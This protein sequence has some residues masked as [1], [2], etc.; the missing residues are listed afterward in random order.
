MHSR[1]LNTIFFSKEKSES[2]KK[3]RI[4]Q[5]NLVHVQGLPENLVKKNLLESAEYFG[6]Y[7]TI[8]KLIIS[9]KI[10]P[11]NK[12]K[13]FSVYITYKNEKEAAITILCIDSL[14]INGKIIRA[15]FGTTKYCT[16]FMNNSICPNSKNCMFLHQ[17]INNKEI[18]IDS[19][20]VFSYNEHL[21]L[22]KKII[23]F[24]NPETRIILS[25][26]KKPKSIFP[27][28]DF[29]LL[30]EEQKEKY[31]GPGNIS[32]IKS[33]NSNKNNESID[34]YL[35]N[36][37]TK[38]NLININNIYNHSINN[39]INNNI[40]NN[41]NVNNIKDRYNNLSYKDPNNSAYVNS[42]KNSY[43]LDNKNSLNNYC[44]NFNDINK[45][46]EPYELC[47]I[48]K[49]SIKHILLSKPFFEN[50]K[51]LPLKRM[52]FNYLKNDLSEKDININ[53]LLNGCLDCLIDYY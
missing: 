35:V 14:L 22:A 39:V 29:I 44:F 28:V 15:F 23:D 13:S 24:N 17:L 1:F 45:N 5:P 21:N 50:I 52:E 8:L 36:K 19:N 4:I 11:E 47:N 42:E 31:F 41:I 26:M 7:G 33:N 6:Q 9:K 48:F 37:E 49:S 12:K 10:N 20:T 18:I 34:N 43:N 32:Y 25:K 53:S 40:I 46:Q 38:F 30:N 16:Y 27:F 51:N 3:L 2:L